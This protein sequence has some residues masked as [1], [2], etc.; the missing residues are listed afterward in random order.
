MN[1]AELHYVGKLLMECASS[2]MQMLGGK[3]LSATELIVAESL[4]VLGPATIGDISRR[5][6]F[7]QS[8]I[9]TVVADMHGRGIVHVR[10][11]DRDR[12]RTIVEISASSMD[13][14]ARV[15]ME[16][17]A[18]TVATWFPEATT[19]QLDHLLAALG[20]ALASLGELPE[21]RQLVRQPVPSVT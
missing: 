8:R 9:S 6:G 21:G 1:L 15:S 19:E 7:V 20:S 2:G 14:V 12:R 11:D 3:H 13:D 17:A 5:T 4:V 10:A 18:P 16:D